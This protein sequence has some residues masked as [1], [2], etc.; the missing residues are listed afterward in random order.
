MHRQWAIGTWLNARRRLRSGRFDHDED[1]TFEARPCPRPQLCCSSAA[2]VSRGAGQAGERDV[3]DH[4]RR[5]AFGKTIIRRID[6]RS[7]RRRWRPWRRRLARGRRLARRRRL[8]WGRR[9]ARWRRLARRWRLAWRRIP[10]CALPPSSLLRWRRLLLSVLRRRLLSLLLSPVLQGCVDPLGSAPHLRLSPPVAPP[11]ASQASLA[12]PLLVISATRDFWQDAEMDKAPDRVPC[13][14]QSLAR[15]A[16]LFAHDLR[17][18]AFRVCR[19]GKPLHT[20]PDHAL[21]PVGELP[22]F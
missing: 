3:I 7:S 5:V 12:P 15:V 18:N 4:A 17:A 19:E 9:L 16:L 14:L 11:L 13:F 6:H 22:G 2:D 10:R 20:F 21:N 8:A 1:G